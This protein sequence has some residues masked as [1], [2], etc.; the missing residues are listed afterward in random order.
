MAGIRLAL[1]DRLVLLL[2]T[3]YLQQGCRLSMRVSSGPGNL[4]LL[5]DQGKTDECHGV[6]KMRHKGQPTPHSDRQFLPQMESG[7]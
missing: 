1:L 2:D 6:R 3:L 7:F 5:V 4:A